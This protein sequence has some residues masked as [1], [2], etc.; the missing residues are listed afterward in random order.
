M[1]MVLAMVLV[2]E[3][4][5]GWGRRKYCK[6]AVAR[7][8]NPGHRAWLAPRFSLGAA[9]YLL[10]MSDCKEA[11]H[12]TQTRSAQGMVRSC[13]LD[14]GLI[15]MGSLHLQRLAALENGFFSECLGRNFHCRVPMLTT[16]QP[17]SQSG[18]P[19]CCIHCPGIAVQDTWYHRMHHR[20]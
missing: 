1:A 18:N 9:G 4:G 16:G 2:Q 11:K 13:S 15:P 19:V 14:P 8:G 6:L 10:R 7:K 3:W 20:A 12:P 17:H 5:R